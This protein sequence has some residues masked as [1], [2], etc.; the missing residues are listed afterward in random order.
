MNR[1]GFLLLTS[2]ATLGLAIA[3]KGLQTFAQ[4]PT[5]PAQLANAT[6]FRI[7]VPQA[8]LDEINRR[9]RAY[10]WH[11]APSGAGWRY[12]S[13]EKHRRADKECKEWLFLP[14]RNSRD[15]GSSALDSAASHVDFHC[16]DGDRRDCL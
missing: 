9:V 4:T 12:G 6:P 14:S 8:K 13:G 3:A 11:E 2:G 1:R 7:N 5:R 10:S 15:H 16:G